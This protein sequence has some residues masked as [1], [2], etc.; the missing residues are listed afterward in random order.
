MDLLLESKG[1]PNNKVR[2]HQEINYDKESRQLDPGNKGTG[3][4]DIESRPTG[5]RI[6]LETREVGE[7]KV[8]DEI[9]KETGRSG[10]SSKQYI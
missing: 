6:E 10:Q 5:Y 3:G 4:L 9:E 8:V 2:E 1:D 7:D